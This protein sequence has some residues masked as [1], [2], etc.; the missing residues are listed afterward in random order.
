MGRRPKRSAA[1]PA[2]K[3]PP[4]RLASEAPPRTPIHA[5]LNPSCGEA[6]LN[7]IPMIPSPNPSQNSPPEA[8]T[9]TR[10]LNHRSGASSYATVG[11][12]V[13]P[14][15]PTVSVEGKEDS[16]LIAG[17]TLARLSSFTPRARLSRLYDF[18]RN[19]VIADAS[20]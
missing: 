19:P 17:D 13:A 6:K 20:A 10:K 18:F 16:A 8:P 12:P 15:A 5:G 11:D 4:K 9:A 14:L 1:G 3:A 7:E 2:N